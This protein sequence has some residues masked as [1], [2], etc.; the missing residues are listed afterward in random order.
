[1]TDSGLTGNEGVFST[2]P[3]FKKTRLPSLYSDFSHLVDSNPEGYDA[4]IQA[5]IE[6][7]K[8]CLEQHTFNS[9]ITLPASELTI[10]LSNKELGE[11]KG[12]GLVLSNQI[13]RGSLVPWSI[14]QFTSPNIATSLRDYVS[15]SKW[16]EKGLARIKTWSFSPTDRKGRLVAENY[17][18]WARLVEIGDDVSKKLLQ[19]V[20]TEG[21]YTANLFDEDLFAKTVLSIVPGLSNLDIQVLI[22]YLSR[23]MGLV[24]ISRDAQSGTQYIKLGSSSLTDHDISIIKLKSSISGLHR[25][26][27][28][29]ENRLDVEIP[30]EIER[31]LSIKGLEDRIKRVLVRKA[32]V[33]RSLAKSLGVLDQLNSIVEK[34]NEADTN[35]V[36]FET[37]KDAKDVLSVYNSKL[38][39]EEIDDLQIE[40]DEQVA[41]T[42][43][44]SAALNNAVTLDDT[45]I[46]EEF[47]R[48][49]KEHEESLRK[50]D[51]P[52]L[53]RD[54]ENTISEASPSEAELAQR[55][56]NLKLDNKSATPDENAEDESKPEPQLA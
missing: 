56:E 12:L 32:A 8:Q 18:A 23:D 13:L 2:V 55:L 25:R 35:A 39:L 37:M 52:D 45:E 43:E 54:S 11:P 15:P 28:V 4:N 46:D 53:A 26:T 6:V 3:A 29:L 41:S 47:A 40:L 7:F 16:F 17:I 33:K 42:N 24:S 36:L 9:S 20:A 50:N 30:Q 51:E 14:Y 1:M 10:K 31:L 21:N 27:T 49:E 38:S 19:M 44:L 5:W 34:I 22:V 48:L